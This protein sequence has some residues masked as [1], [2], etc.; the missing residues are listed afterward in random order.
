MRGRRRDLR[1]VDRDDADL[2]QAAARAQR[3]H[4]AEQV[5]DRAL[6]A[7]P[8]ARDHRVIGHAV[9][10]DHAKRDVLATAPLDRPRR[11]HP[12]RVGVDE[13]R[14]H[15]RRIVRRATPPVIAIRR[16]KRRQVH[17]RD[18]VEHE[19]HQVLLRQP[20]AQARRQQQ[21]LLAITLDE[22]LRHQRMVLNPPDATPVCAT[23]SARRDSELSLRASRAART[24]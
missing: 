11:A 16:V 15:H 3:Q 2:D 6:V 9:G 21:L 13:Q 10:A 7:D 8:E 20:L 24:S 4:P 5:G 12:D 22:V 14:H 1:P 17:L 19:P 18:G 23:P